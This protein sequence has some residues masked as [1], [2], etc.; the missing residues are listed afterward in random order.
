MQQIF[1]IL[2]E[3]YIRLFEHRQ[4]CLLVVISEKCILMSCIV[5]QTKQKVINW[6][7]SCTQTW[8]YGSGNAASP[9]TCGWAV[10]W[11]H[12]G[13]PAAVGAPR[14]RPASHRCL[15]PASSWTAPSPASS[16]SAPPA[17]SPRPAQ[18]SAFTSG[19]HFTGRRSITLNIGTG[20]ND[21][22]YTNAC[23]DVFRHI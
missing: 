7:A 21:Q 8:G 1:S 3:K 14:E 12:G 20:A 4:K 2:Q 11:W 13:L 9:V 10:G 15:S 23:P 22:F 19:A 5:K 17:P 16:R 18:R 6:S